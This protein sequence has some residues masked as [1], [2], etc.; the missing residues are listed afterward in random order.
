ML[1]NLLIIGMSGRIF[2]QS[3]PAAAAAWEL[4]PQAQ[5]NCSIGFHLC[6]SNR[7]LVLLIAAGSCRDNAEGQKN[8]KEDGT[9]FFHQV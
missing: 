9:K 3:F 7:G 6:G 8:A 1:K 4:G 5:D 2:E